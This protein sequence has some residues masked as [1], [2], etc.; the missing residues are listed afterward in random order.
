MVMLLI[1]KPISCIRVNVEMIDVGMATA[2][3]NVARQLAMNNIT[4]RLTSTAA[5]TRWNCTSWMDSLMKREWSRITCSV[6]SPGSTVCSCSKRCLMRSMTS[7][8]LVP[9]CLRTSRETA[10]LP[11]RRARLRGST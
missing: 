1:V 9:D 11:S 7:T 6:T 3:I 10:G 2:A 8:V 4:V 5:R